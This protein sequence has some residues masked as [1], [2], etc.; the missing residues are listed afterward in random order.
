MGHGLPST[1]AQVVK[2][3]LAMENSSDVCSLLFWVLAGLQLLPH[4]VKLFFYYTF[5]KVT[6]SLYKALFTEVS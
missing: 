5:V 1:H 3:M 2:C 4:T 6:L